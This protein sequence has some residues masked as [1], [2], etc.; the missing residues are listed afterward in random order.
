MH[1]K[2]ILKNENNDTKIEVFDLATLWASLLLERLSEHEVH[3]Y[4]IFESDRIVCRIYILFLKLCFLVLSENNL[5][6]TCVITFCFSPEHI[7]TKLSQ[8]FRKPVNAESC[9]GRIEISR[10]KMFASI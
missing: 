10:K 3:N 9:N 5:E 6:L 1:R 4:H 2:C 7:A 8:S